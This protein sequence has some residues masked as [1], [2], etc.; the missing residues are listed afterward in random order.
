M[1]QESKTSDEAFTDFALETLE[2]A[3]DIGERT[4]GAR[5]CGIDYCEL[6]ETTATIVQLKSQDSPRA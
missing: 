5:D 3:T 2:F 4:D 1:D 6:T